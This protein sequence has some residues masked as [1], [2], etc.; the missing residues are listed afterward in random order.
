MDAI[1]GLSAEASGGADMSQIW[2][3][4]SNQVGFAIK[5]TLG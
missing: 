3:E 1:P 4:L 5:H 2:F